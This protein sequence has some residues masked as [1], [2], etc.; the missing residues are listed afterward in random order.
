M[1]TAVLSSPAVEAYVYIV[2]HRDTGRSYVGQTRKHPK[3][4]WA[5]HRAHARKGSKLPFHAALRKYGVEAFDWR[6]AWAGPEN[7][8]NAVERLLIAESGDFNCT[9][10]GD[11]TAGWAHRDETKAKISESAKARGQRPP[12]NIGTEAAR[13]AHAGAKRPLEWRAKIGASLRARGPLAGLSDEARETHKRA[14]QAAYYAAHADELR[15]RARAS[16]RARYVPRPR[17]KMSEEA[18]KQA[19]R[20]SAAKW[21]AANPDK[22]R[23]QRVKRTEVRRARKA[24]S[25]SA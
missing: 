14:V 22:V 20:L 13:K 2:T 18:F 15:A 17:S 6:V 12:P 11:G 3:E 10:G 21:R 4:R 1:T 23:E 19:R 25:W 8:L 9:D 5:T 24:A 7:L 16:A